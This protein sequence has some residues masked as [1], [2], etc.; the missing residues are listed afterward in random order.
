MEV[1]QRLLDRNTVKMCFAENGPIIT[2]TNVSKYYSHG[3]N[4]SA[5][6]DRLRPGVRRERLIGPNPALK[7][8]RDYPALLRFP[9]NI[10]LQH[11][12]VREQ[13]YL[14]M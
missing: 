9:L 1:Q 5:G 6:L 11:L 8:P 14:R 7:L 10:S 12:H 13:K 2:S 4:L 3:T